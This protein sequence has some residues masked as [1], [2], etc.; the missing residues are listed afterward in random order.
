MLITKLLSILISVSIF[1][2]V[3]RDLMKQK[4]NESNSILWLVIAVLIFITGVFPNTVNWLAAWVG[5]GYSPA[6]LFLVA[7]VVLFLIAFKSSMDISKLDARVTELAIAYSLANEEN[8]LLKQKLIKYEEN[9]SN[10]SNILPQ[11]PSGEEPE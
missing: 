7:T 11:E 8:R 2:I 6:L 3:I 5:I 10:I 1:V 9:M 4:M